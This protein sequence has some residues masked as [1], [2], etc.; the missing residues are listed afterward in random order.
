M[1]AKFLFRLLMKIDGENMR[2]LISDL[3][4]EERNDIQ[5]P[6]R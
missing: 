4:E 3:E 5:R 6:K 2:Q 1:I